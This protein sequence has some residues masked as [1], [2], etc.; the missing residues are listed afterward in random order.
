MSHLDYYA[1][2]EPDRDYDI[3]A[4]ADDPIICQAPPTTSNSRQSANARMLF[5]NFEFPTYN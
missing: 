1:D 3:Y 4:M 5:F 2:I